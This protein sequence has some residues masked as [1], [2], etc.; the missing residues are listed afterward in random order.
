MPRRQQPTWS[1]PYPTGPFNAVFYADGGETPTPADIAPAPAA[2]PQE[3]KSNKPRPAETEGEL[4]VSRDWLESRLTVE[5][6]AGRRNGNQRLAADLGFEDVNGLRSFVD[7]R[8]K[9]EQEAMSET[10]RRVQELETRERQLAAREA[11]AQAAL[12]SASRR[13]LLV[14]LGATGDDLEDATAL[15]RVTNDATDEEVR[16][17]AD[18][19]KERRPE[20][21]GATGAPA[22]QPAAPMAPT[23]LPAAGMPRPGAS[24]PKPGERGLEMLRRRGK[25]PRNNDAA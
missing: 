17:A 9:A 19:L 18:K 1:H 12:V 25:A 16:E 8:R 22:A 4:I 24:Q 3:R 7:E 21:F 14:T 11:Q 10:E 20:L 2:P 15:L 6:D 13:A 5:K 23:G